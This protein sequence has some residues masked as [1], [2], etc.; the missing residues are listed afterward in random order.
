MNEKINK[1][2][3]LKF[4]EYIRQSEPLQ[5]EAATRTTVT[6]TGE[7]TKGASVSWILY[8]MLTLAC[9]HPYSRLLLGLLKSMVDVGRKEP[10]KGLNDGRSTR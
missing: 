4:D 8:S 1:E 3:F 2:R 6:R 9:F 7:N 10:E 5:R